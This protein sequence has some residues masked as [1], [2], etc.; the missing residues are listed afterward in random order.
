[1]HKGRLFATKERAPFS[2][3]IEIYRETEE[4]NLKD[5]GEAEEVEAEV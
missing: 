2:V 1:M 5:E 4:L 3:W